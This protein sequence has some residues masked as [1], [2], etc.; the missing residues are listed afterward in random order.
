MEITLAIV[1]S[2]LFLISGFTQGQAHFVVVAILIS[3]WGDYE[4]G[5]YLHETYGMMLLIIVL[6]LTKIVSFVY[7][8]ERSKIWDDLQSELRIPSNRDR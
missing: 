8:N 4:I 6:T 1:F 5:S 3:V 7:F 2:A